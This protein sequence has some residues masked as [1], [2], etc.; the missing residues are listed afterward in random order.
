M[1]QHHPRAHPRAEAERCRSRTWWEL[2]SPVSIL[3]GS[4]EATQ[5]WR[6]RV[7]SP[8]AHLCMRAG[9]SRWHLQQPRPLPLG[10]P[11]S[12]AVD[13]VQGFSPLLHQQVPTLETPKG[14]RALISQQPQNSSSGTQHCLLGTLACGSHSPLIFLLGQ[15]QLLQAWPAMPVPKL[16]P[17]ATCKRAGLE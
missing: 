1:A 13:A 12:Q 7:G 11:V 2:T 6:P 10:L 8:L 9:F 5:P 14:L 4:P 17:T 16:P 15:Q 3:L